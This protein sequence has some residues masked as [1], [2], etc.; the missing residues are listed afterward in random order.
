MSTGTAIR[1]VQPTGH[2]RS[3]NISRLHMS[4]ITIF[5]RYVPHISI[6]V[7]I[8]FSLFTSFEGEQLD[9]RMGSSAQRNIDSEEP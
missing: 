1:S 7:H 9:S 3:V 6:P 2:C 8:H 5:H 4:F